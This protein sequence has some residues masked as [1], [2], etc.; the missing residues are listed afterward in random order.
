MRE[1]QMAPAQSADSLI[2]EI[3][4]ALLADRNYRG[5]DWSAIALAATLDGGRK[6]LFGYAY[7]P[8]G[9]WTAMTPGDARRVI[10]LLR[11]L[12]E[13]MQADGKGAWR[14]C[15]VQLKREDMKINLAF[16]YDDPQRWKVTPGNL[17]ETVE[18]L[19]PR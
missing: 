4:R 17:R 8:D 13:T 5:G 15:L 12:Q 7:L 3:G 11:D 14:Q 9:S 19:R 6:S 1:L 2:V 16:E 10:N 18:A